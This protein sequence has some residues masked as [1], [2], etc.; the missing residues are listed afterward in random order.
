MSQPFKFTLIQA[1]HRLCGPYVD[2]FIRTRVNF[3]PFC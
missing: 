3:V 2:L 1:D